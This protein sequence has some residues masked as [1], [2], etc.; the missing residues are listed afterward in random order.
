MPKSGT[1]STNHVPQSGTGSTKHWLCHMSDQSCKLALP[2]FGFTR[3]WFN[4]MV[5]LTNKDSIMHCLSQNRLYKSLAH[6]HTDY[7]KYWL[8]QALVLPSIECTKH[9]L[10]KTWLSQALTVSGAG[11]TGRWSC[12]ENTGSDKNL[13]TACVGTGCAKALL[14]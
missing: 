1:V 4:Q 9:G 2:G 7:F 10:Y 12:Q 14:L 3:Y 13:N 8:Y 11:H 5:T 6:L